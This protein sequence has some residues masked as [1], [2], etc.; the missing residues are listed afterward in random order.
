M[1]TDLAHMAPAFGFL[2]ERGFSASALAPWPKEFGA[3]ALL[4][5]GWPFS[6]R[7]EAASECG[8]PATVDLGSNVLGWH[9]LE[10][11]LEFVEPGVLQPWQGGE[12]PGPEAMAGLLQSRWDSIA[13]LFNDLEQTAG[14]Q[15]YSRQRMANPRLRL[16]PAG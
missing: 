9:R 3:V 16:S 1:S 10:H 2:A 12:S 13:A 15:A 11:V 7:F 4:M 8:C 5:V 6:L 14:L